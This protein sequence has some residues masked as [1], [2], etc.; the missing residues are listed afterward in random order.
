MK[1]I[2]PVSEKESNKVKDVLSREEIVNIFKALKGL[3]VLK[4][5]QETDKKY[6]QHLVYENQV[7][8]WRDF[9]SEEEKRKLIS[10]S[11][12][13]H[14]KAGTPWAL[15]KAFEALGLNAKIVEWFEYGVQAPKFKVEV[16]VSEKGIDL[17]RLKD[18]KEFILTYKNVRSILDKT[19]VFL[20]PLVE[21]KEA[22]G[23]SVSKTITL[24]PFV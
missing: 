4:N 22:V 6:F 11:A 18:L 10:D 9:L 23:F 2:L 20:K 7:D 13:V 5:S 3:Q 1:T 15:K 19:E 14:S 8:F 21:Q 16:D 17:S 12:L 24:K